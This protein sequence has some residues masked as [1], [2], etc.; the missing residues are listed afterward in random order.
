LAL[1]SE[2]DI[3]ISIY[4]ISANGTQI[5]FVTMTQGADEMEGTWTKYHLPEKVPF[6]QD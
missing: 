2:G 4:N 1:L 6:R 3:I 5:P